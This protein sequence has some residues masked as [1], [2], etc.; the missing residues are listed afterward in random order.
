[1]YDQLSKQ[2]LQ[3]LVSLFHIFTIKKFCYCHLFLQCWILNTHGLRGHHPLATL[4]AVLWHV[5]LRAGTMIR[6]MFPH[7]LPSTDQSLTLLSL[8]LHISVILRHQVSL[9]Q[10]HVFFRMM[11]AN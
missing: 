5:T 10:H 7:V 9:M 8:G 1:M 6:V 2:L 3:C 11:W 4:P